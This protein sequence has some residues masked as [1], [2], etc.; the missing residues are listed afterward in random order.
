GFTRHC[1][2]PL[3]LSSVRCDRFFAE[4]V[5]SRAQRDDRPLA[6]MRIGQGIVDHVDFGIV[7]DLLV[8][9]VNPSDAMGGGK[10]LGAL[11]IPRRHRDYFRIPYLQG[12]LDQGIGSDLC[13]TQG[14]KTDRML[15]WHLLF[16]TSASIYV[17]ETSQT[18]LRKQSLVDSQ[19]WR[20]VR[21]TSQGG[22]PKWRPM[23][24]I[25]L[26]S[27][28]AVAACGRAGWPQPS[29]PNRRPPDPPTSP[30]PPS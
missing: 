1:R 21:S 14:A 19:G 22:L 16:P 17:P 13:G 3:R 30:P 9:V 20:G 23:I 2:H 29:P 12:R 27:A 8:G 6:M 5:L 4:H 26:L 7:D 18:R 10:I 24:S 15:V 28:P 11:A 25:F